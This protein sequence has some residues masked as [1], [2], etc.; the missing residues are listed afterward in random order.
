MYFN[1]VNNVNCPAAH[2]ANYYSHIAYLGKFFLKRGEWGDY[3][4]TYRDYDDRESAIQEVAEKFLMDI[5]TDHGLISIEVTLDEIV[6]DIWTTILALEP[7]GPT[8]PPRGVVWSAAT[9]PSK[10]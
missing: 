6:A 10:D 5:A 1:T 2:R 3:I 8:T 4:D 7:L 9:L